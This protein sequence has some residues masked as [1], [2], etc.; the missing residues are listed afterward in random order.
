MKRHVTLFYAVRHVGGAQLLFARTVAEL[1]ARHGWSIGLVDYEDGFVRKTLSESG[2]SFDFIPYGGSVGPIAVRDTVLLLGLGELPEALSALAGTPETRILLW[3]IHPHNPLAFFRHGY[4]YNRLK[5]G[6][7]TGAVRSLEPRRWNRVRSLFTA[8]HT[9]KALAFMDGANVRYAETLGLGVPESPFLPVPLAMKKTP[10]ARVPTGA[11][12]V[13]W[14][15]RLGKDKFNTL[16]ATLQLCSRYAQAQK[17]DVEY[18][19]IG[20]GP[21]LPELTGRIFP[22]VRLVLAGTLRDV[23]LDQYLVRHV[24]VG[25]AMGTSILEIALLGIPVVVSD[26]SNRPIPPDALALRWASQITQYTLGEVVGDNPLRARIGIDD[27]MRVCKNPDENRTVGSECFSY[28]RDHHSM[29]RVGVLLASRLEETSF[30]LE[31]ARAI[32]GSRRIPLGPALARAAKWIQG[33]P[34]P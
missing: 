19:V 25:F 21:M 4:L 12:S 27:I 10:E 23:A 3:G 33:G 17:A 16:I 22:G 1:F 34:R 15:G 29:E 32:V 28:A 5:P 6:W 9:R 31:E 13:G 30:P 2:V 20:E 14:L 26:Y 8:L 7:R 18:H 11:L 24:Q